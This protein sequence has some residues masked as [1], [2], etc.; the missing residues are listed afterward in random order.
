MSSWLGRAKPPYLREAMTSGQRSCGPWRVE[1]GLQGHKP[2]PWAGGSSSFRAHSCSGVKVSMVAEVVGYLP[3]SDS[4]G[5]AG[6][7]AKWSQTQGKDVGPCF[8]SAFRIRAS[9]VSSSWGHARARQ[10]VPCFP[11]VKP[12]LGHTF[13]WTPWPM[14]YVTLLSSVLS[15]GAVPIKS[16]NPLGSQSFQMS[17]C[18]CKLRQPTAHTS[19]SFLKVGSMLRAYCLPTRGCPG[20]C[21]P[22]ILWNGNYPG[23]AGTLIDRPLSFHRSPPVFWPVLHCEAASGPERTGGPSDTLTSKQPNFSFWGAEKKSLTLQAACYLWP[24]HRP[25]CGTLRGQEWG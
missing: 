24:M 10:S 3:P 15:R 13:G 7:V 12:C 18:P 6:P 1:S 4:P 5:V 17:Y 25:Q 19:V 20:S 8:I 11:G 9:H 21:C 23:H 14:S 2:W 16:N 22:H